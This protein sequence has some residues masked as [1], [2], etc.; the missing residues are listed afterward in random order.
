MR[1]SLSRILI[2]GIVAAVAGCSDAAT[3]TSL[4]APQ[5]LRADRSS[6][7]HTKTVKMLDQCDPLTFNAVLGDGA[8]VRN[9]GLKFEQFIAQVTRMQQ[10]PGWRFSPENV[11]L[12]VGDILAATNFG[13][14][15]HT[16]TEVEEFGGG[17]VGL[18]NDLAGTPKVAEECKGLSFA[19]AVAPGATVTEVVDEAGDEK[20]QCCIHPWM[21]AVVH[22]SA[23]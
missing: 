17:F 1:P 16:F 9:G 3:P 18:L 6:G 5:A 14:E 21:R 10:A 19:D 7:E 11:N 4:S 23:K 13:G 22:V 8:C 2:A 20:Y 12:R 15:G